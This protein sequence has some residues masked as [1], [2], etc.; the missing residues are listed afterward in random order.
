[1]EQGNS[2]ASWKCSWSRMNLV[3]CQC[4]SSPRVGGLLA[5]DLLYELFPSP[6]CSSSCSLHCSWSCSPGCLAPTPPQILTNAAPAFAYPYLL[7]GHLRTEESPLEKPMSV[8]PGESPAW[9]GPGRQSSPSAPLCVAAPCP[10]RLATGCPGGAARRPRRGAGAMGSISPG[11]SLQVQVRLCQPRAVRINASCTD[12]ETWELLSTCV[13]ESVR[14]TFWFSSFV[15]NSMNEKS[16]I[17]SGCCVG[18]FF[19]C[20]VIQSV[21]LV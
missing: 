20:S 2:W 17:G 4:S 21:L 1:M 18:F 19:F 10:L 8:W 7:P 13:N 16:G 12:P 14:N 9:R 15:L 3:L 11:L 5:G 6:V